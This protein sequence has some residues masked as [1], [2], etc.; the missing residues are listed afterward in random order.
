M[1]R[2]KL[3]EWK[4]GNHKSRIALGDKLFFGYK[5]EKGCYSLA[6]KDGEIVIGVKCKTERDCL[7]VSNILNKV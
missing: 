2:K 7:I 6:I 3:L 4:D 1:K 5:K